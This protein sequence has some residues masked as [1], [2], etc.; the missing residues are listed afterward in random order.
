MFAFELGREFRLSLAE[1]F[2][3][4]PLGNTIFCDKKILILD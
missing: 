4:F 1:I 3:V 2:V